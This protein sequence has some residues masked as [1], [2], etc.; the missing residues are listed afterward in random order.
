MPSVLIARSLA[1]AGALVG[2][3]L[4]LFCMENFQ[5]RWRIPL[6]LW[7]ALPLPLAYAAGRRLTGGRASS[8]LAGGMA[9]AFATGAGLYWDAFLGPSSRTESMA[10]LIVL[11]A[12]LY[13]IIWLGL[14]LA[15]AW[16]TNRSA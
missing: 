9:V 15:A 12:P 10:G 5:P 11:Y 14:V 8:V 13:Q 6:S 1:I 7:A 2:V 3:W 16:V 4:F